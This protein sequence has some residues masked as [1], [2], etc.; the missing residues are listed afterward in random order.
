MFSPGMGNLRPARVF[1]TAGVWWGGS[2]ASS[3]FF[4][5]E[6]R[7]IRERIEKSKR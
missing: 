6:N 1:N 2:K 7:E 5:D 4:R 3:S